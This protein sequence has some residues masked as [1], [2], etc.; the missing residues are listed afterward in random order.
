MLLRLALNAVRVAALA[1][2]AERRIRPPSFTSAALTRVPP[3]SIPRAI[4][5]R[6]QCIT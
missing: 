6:V 1:V 2:W 3:M 5:K 4:G